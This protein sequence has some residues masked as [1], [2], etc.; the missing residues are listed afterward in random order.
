MLHQRNKSFFGLKELG[1]ILLSLEKRIV[2]NSC[3]Y[4][5]QGLQFC[6]DWQVDRKNA[7]PAQCAVHLDH[8]VMGLND[9]LCQREAQADALGV[10]RACLISSDEDGNEGESK[11]LSRNN[12]FTL[13]IFPKP[14]E[15]IQPAEKAL[16][17]PTTR[18]HNKS[19]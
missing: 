11:N 3:S 14:A 19:V 17:H 6:W 5:A 1:I 2:P 4:M 10:L 9:G 8:T 12:E 16:Y 15:F 7:S 13:T 18:Q